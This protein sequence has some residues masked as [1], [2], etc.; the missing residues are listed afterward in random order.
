MPKTEQERDAEWADLVCP[1]PVLRFTWTDGER[2][3]IAVH[4]CGSPLHVEHIRQTYLLAGGE[5][6]IVGPSWRVICEGGHT[7]LLPDDQ[8]N[9]DIGE[10]TFDVALVQEALVGIGVLAEGDGNINLRESGA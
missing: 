9:D 5:M 8:G 2:G 3:P 6:D 1:L 4:H 10:L 7:L